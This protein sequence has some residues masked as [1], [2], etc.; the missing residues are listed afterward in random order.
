ML[1]YN[2]TVNVDFELKENWVKWM[3]E[4]HIPNVMNTGKF[5][6]YQMLRLIGDENSGGVTY[7]TQYYCKDMATLLA[8][9]R[10]DAPN[11]QN[12]VKL[13][14]PNG[15]HAFRSVLEVIK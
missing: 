2:V 6:K 7:A 14:F 8:Y 4:V 9:Q 1:V 15:V 10:D 12:E 11:L 3:T 5:E 13:E